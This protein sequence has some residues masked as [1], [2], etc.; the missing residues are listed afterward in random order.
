MTYER[1]TKSC[2][3]DDWRLRARLESVRQPA[4]ATVLTVLVE[5]HLPVYR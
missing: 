3:L 1:F 2:K 5:C 4:L